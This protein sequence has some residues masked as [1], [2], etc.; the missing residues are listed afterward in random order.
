M[1]HGGAS[2]SSL[3]ALT[4]IYGLVMVNRLEGR[5]EDEGSALGVR[6]P[7]SS[8][9]FH[10]L[11]LWPMFFFLCVSDGEQTQILWQRVSVTYPLYLV[12]YFPTEP[13]KHFIFIMIGWHGSVV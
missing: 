4:W 5:D 8:L 2:V 3:N 6:S 10:V 7:L 13:R 11:L 12:F 1:C 9:A